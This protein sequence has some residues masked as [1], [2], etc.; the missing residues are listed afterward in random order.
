MAQQTRKAAGKEMTAPKELQMKVDFSKVDGKTRRAEGSGAQEF[1][2]LERTG[3]LANVTNKSQNEELGIDAIRVWEPTKGQEEAGVL[4]KVSLYTKSAKIDNI[5]IFPS[6][7][8][9]GDIYLQMGGGRNIAEPGQK[10]KWVRDCK[11]T[12]PAKA[13]VLSYVYSLL[14]KPE[15]V[16][17]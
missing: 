2:Y 3:D 17:E 6:K 8:A 7:H 12:S 15:D 10:A 9:E 1:W 4:C 11:L 16:G 13:Q 14:E 5:S